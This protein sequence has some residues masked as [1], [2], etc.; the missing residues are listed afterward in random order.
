MIVKIKNSYRQGKRKKNGILRKSQAN[1]PFPIDHFF[2]GNSFL[3]F[4]S[5]MNLK[6]RGSI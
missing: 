1:K 4:S 5:K 3:V 6:Y 2:L